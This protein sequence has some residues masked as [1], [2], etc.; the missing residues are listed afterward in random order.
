[1]R[2]TQWKCHTGLFRFR[3]LRS[4]RWAAAPSSSSPELARAVGRNDAALDCQKSTR[5]SRVVNSNAIIIG[6]RLALLTASSCP[7][8]AGSG[9]PPPPHTHAVCF[10]VSMPTKRIAGRALQTRTPQLQSER[11]ESDCCR[12]VIRCP[13]SAS[14]TKLRRQSGALCC[15]TSVKQSACRR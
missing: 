2:R 11:R 7:R 5:L 8:D 10:P 6:L 13:R 14:R 3:M 15:M 1:M 12:R 9:T 4:S